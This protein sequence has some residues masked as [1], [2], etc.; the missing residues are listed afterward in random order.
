MLE[1]LFKTIEEKI[2]IVSNYCE[3]LDIFEDLCK[4]RRYP[5]VRLD[6]KTNI[7]I[8]QQIVDKFNETNVRRSDAFVFLLSAKAGGCGLSLHGCNRM[9]LLDPDWNPSNDQ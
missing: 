5:W 9:I 4:K 8:R 6:G 3:T 1:K 2:I 7:A